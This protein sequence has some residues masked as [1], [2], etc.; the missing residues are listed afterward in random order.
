MHQERGGKW[1]DGIENASCSCSPHV[2][3][4]AHMSGRD[5]I[6]GPGAVQ[7]PASVSSRLSHKSFT[8]FVPVLTDENFFHDLLFLVSYSFRLMP[9]STTQFIQSSAT[10]FAKS[11]ESGKHLKCSGTLHSKTVPPNTHDCYIS[12]LGGT[13]E[14]FSTW[15][16]YPAADSSLYR[17]ISSLSAHVRLYTIFGGQQQRKSTLSPTYPPSTFTFY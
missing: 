2:S 15:K 16:R 17:S 12:F 5:N 11:F 4:D 7:L 6:T 3:I 10:L 1:H 14:F 8:N 13:V 9:L